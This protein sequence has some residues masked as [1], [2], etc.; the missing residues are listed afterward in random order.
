MKENKYISPEARFLDLHLESFICVSIKDQNY[1]V[2]VDGYE[3]YEHTLNF[4]E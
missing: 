2:E 3:E 1:G 4:D